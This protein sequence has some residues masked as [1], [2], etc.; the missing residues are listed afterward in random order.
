MRSVLGVFK[1]RGLFFL[2]SRTTKETVAESLAAEMGVRTG[3]RR[4]EIE[5]TITLAR[6]RGSVIAIGHA[7]RQTPRVV[8]AMRAEFDRQGVVLVPLSSLMR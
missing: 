8:A 7:H 3:R 1:E 6:S 5:R 2:D 4:Q